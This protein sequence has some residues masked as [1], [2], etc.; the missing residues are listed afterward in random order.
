VAAPSPA[1]SPTPATD[2]TPAGGAAAEIKM[3]PTLAFDKTELTIPADTE[4]TITVDNA[5]IGV[6]HNFAV[7]TSRDAAESGE[8]ALVATDICIGPCTDT[9][10]LN[11]GVG[12]YFFRCDVHPTIMVGTI[13]VE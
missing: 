11:L 1:A 9:A 10:T 5:D 7:Y 13:T 4:V 3:I 2:E 8:A 6:P 12:E